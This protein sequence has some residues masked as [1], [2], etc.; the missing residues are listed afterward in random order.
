MTAIALPFCPHTTLSY[1][2]EKKLVAPQ[3]TQN[4]YFLLLNHLIFA[5]KSLIFRIV[6]FYFQNM[7]F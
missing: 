6:L 7:F 3:A 1:L 5:A 2:F 4:I